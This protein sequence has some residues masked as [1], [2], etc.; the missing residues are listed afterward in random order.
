MDIEKFT[1]ENK[2]RNA[3]LD[4][5]Y[6]PVTGEGGP[7]ERQEV[8]FADR[9]SPLFLPVGM[10]NVPWVNF[11][12]SFRSLSDASAA[13]HMKPEEILFT[14]SEERFKH[15]FEFWAATT[16]R[17]KPKT[18]GDFI[19]FFLNRPQRKVH[20]VTWKQVLNRE[21]VRQILLKSRQFGGSTYYQVFMGYIQV[22]HKTNWNSLVAAHLNQSATN[23]RHMFSTLARY[24]PKGLASNFTIKGFENT[25]NIKIIPE[26]NCKITIGSI[27]TPDSVRADDVAM[28]HL[29]EIGLWKKTEGKSPEDL[30]QSIL[31]TIPT[32]PWSVYV[33]ESTAKGVGNFFH[34][35]WQ[36]AV[37]GKNGLT[38]VFIPWMEDPKN[39]VP[40]RSKEEMVS[41]INT[42]SD[43][44]LY[45]WQLGATLEGISFYR[46][47]LREMNGDGWRMKS[48]FPSTPQEAFQSTGQRVFAPSYVAAVRQDCTGPVFKGEVFA[49][50][51]RGK[52][53][54]DKVRFEETREGNLWVWAMPDLTEKIENRYC[55]F[56]DIG[57][58]TRKA[59]YSALKIFDRYWMLDGG[60]PEVAAVWHGHLDQDLFAWKCAQICKMYGNALLAVEVN[61]LKKEKTEGDHFLT[62]LDEI[63]PYY[64]EL[65]IRNDFEKV[66]DGYVP[67]YGFQ[68][69]V[70]TKGLIIN[71]LNAAARERMM[72]DSGQD[73]GYYYIERDL[74]AADEMDWYEVKPDGTLG[75]VEGEHD[76]LVIVTAGGVWLATKFMK[77]P[78]RIK[79]GSQVKK[80]ILRSEASF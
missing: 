25:S 41:L 61:S 3:L 52:E 8:A 79:T 17:I 14:L 54:L 56:A 47:K 4:G 38:P 69:N 12:A 20:A 70:K 24:Y 10:L 68:T 57:G 43:Y 31:G 23:I 76:D 39:R 15:D 37:S 51:R 18:G 7:L 27:E 64:R 35:S 44:E 77:P 33:L 72:K 67:K 45:L 42:L 16:A 48:E 46:F 32:V 60:S 73:E 9:E 74:R 21:P 6:N 80:R 19:P 58:R 40:F 11:L 2:K 65:Y 1:D 22:I 36:N 78:V 50:A 13:L 34:R 26:R 71:S 62:V 55:A 29:S 28:A 5:P 66:G 63:A 75:A 53:A 30:C 49:R 59:D